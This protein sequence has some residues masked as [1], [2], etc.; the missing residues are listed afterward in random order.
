MRGCG[1]CLLASFE[2]SDIVWNRYF[3]TK[4][5]VSLCVCKLFLYACLN[6][7]CLWLCRRGLG[8]LRGLVGHFSRKIHN[9]PPHSNTLPLKCMS[10]ATLWNHHSDL[11]QYYTVSFCVWGRSHNVA[12]CISKLGIL[13]KY[14]KHTFNKSTESFGSWRTVCMTALCWNPGINLKNR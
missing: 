13:T 10:P 8:L 7:A 1:Y 6:Y 12:T 9:T 4:L 3:L 11:A 2:S 5:T 14:I